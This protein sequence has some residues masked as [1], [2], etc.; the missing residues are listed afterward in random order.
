MEEITLGVCEPMPPKQIYQA[1]VDC[2]SY[3]NRH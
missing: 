1:V 2:C 3:T